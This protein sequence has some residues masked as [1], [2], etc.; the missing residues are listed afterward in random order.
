MTLLDQWTGTLPARTKK[1]HHI[2][3]VV[4]TIKAVISTNTASTI[5][6]TEVASNTRAERMIR[7][8]LMSAN[9][10]ANI[11]K[12]SP[13]NI[14]D[15]MTQTRPINAAAPDLDPQIVRPP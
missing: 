12:R 6:K 14:I 13:K 8:I 15:V 1:N 3:A 4:T 10:A 11:T 9:T 5:E 2:R 7:I